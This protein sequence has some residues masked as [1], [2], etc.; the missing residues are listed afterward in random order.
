MFRSTFSTTTM[1]SSTTMPMAS[2]RPKSESVLMLKPS[3]SMTAKVPI[4][5]HGHGRQRDD[6][7]PPGLQK[8][9]DDDHHQHHGFEQ[10]VDHR[11]DRADARRPSDRRPPN[12]RGRPGSFFFSSSI[13][14]ADVLGK[15]DGVRAGRLEDGDGDGR[16]VVQQRA[17]RVCRRAQF[18]AGDILERM[19]SLR[20]GRS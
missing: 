7:R 10:R 15:L 3:A 5:R 9:D 11:L 18:D 20:S 13:V 6:R 4:K 12:S 8:E 16:L 2:T 17:Q 1:A 14:A 19:L